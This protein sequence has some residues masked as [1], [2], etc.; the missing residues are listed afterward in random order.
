MPRVCT[1]ITRWANF[2]AD[3]FTPWLTLA[4]PTNSNMRA[5][6]LDSVVHKAGLFRFM[7]L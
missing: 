6:A 4:V 7:H 2:I 3:S 5:L 1:R